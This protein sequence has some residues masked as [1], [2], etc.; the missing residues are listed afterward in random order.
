MRIK[1]LALKAFGPFSDCTLDFSSE[2]PGL[3]VVYGLN[4]AG[5]S[6]SL[7]ALHA[8]FFGFPVRTADNFLHPNDHLLVGGSLQGEDGQELTF[9]R[10]KKS[11]N[12]LFD[13]H[14]NPL[15]PAVLTPFLHGLEQ[16]TFNTLYGIDHDAL[17]RGGQ[18]ILDQQGEVGQALFAAGTGLASL[19]SI[20]DELDGEGDKLFRPRGSSQAI[21]VALTEYR[22]L[23]TQIKQLTLLSREWQGHQRTLD[24]AKKKLENANELRG[25]LNREKRQLER[26]KQALPYLGQRRTLQGK[27]AE[28]GDVVELPFDF[29]D[30]RRKL[31]QQIE[32]ARSRIEAAKSRLHDLKEKRKGISLKQEL[33]DYSDEI[34]ALI[35][36]LG[37]YRKGNIDRPQL[38]G[39]RIG[40]RTEAAKLLKQ[41]RPEISI[42]E[43]E[44]LRPSL[45]KR[46]TIQILGSRHEALLQRVRDTSRLAQTTAKELEK[47]QDDLQK[48]SS[49]VDIEKLSRTITM[50]QK[51]GDLDRDI[52]TKRQNLNNAQEGCLAV[53]SRLGLW[54]GSLELVGQ[55]AVPLPETLHRNEE[56][57]RYLAGEIKQMQTECG[58]LESELAQLNEQLREI[59][60]AADVPNVEELNQNRSRRDQGWKLLRRQWLQGEDVAAESHD[61]DPIHPLPEAYEKLVSISDQTAD[62][63]YREADRVQKHASLRA[64]AEGIEKLLVELN[65]KKRIVEHS[66]AVATRSWEALWAP[67]AINPLPPREMNAWL[68]RFDK[69]RFQVQEADKLA[70]DIKEH[71]VRRRE[72]RTILMAELAAIGEQQ[73]FLGEILS[74]VLQ[75]AEALVR[76][77]QGDQSRREKLTEKIHDLER[78]LESALRDQNEA[79]E[80]LSLWQSRWDE[81]LTP[82]GIERNTLPA[83]AVDFIE[84]LQGCFEKLKEADDFRK[85]IDGID[86]D[87]RGFEEA[88]LNLANQIAPEIA[89]LD[90]I[91][92]VSQL[93]IKLGLA[94][95]DKAL[96]QKYSEDVDDLEKI[97]ID[98]RTELGSFDEQMKAMLH[99]ARCK[100]PEQLI[101]AELRS[102]EYLKL[103]D[104][105][106]EVDVNL[107]RIAEGISLIDLE[108]Q[109]KCI[110]PNALPDRIDGLTKEAEDSIDPEIRQLSEIVG[111]E[112][113]E[114]ARMDGSGKVA[115]LADA[116]QQA[117]VKVQRLTERYIRL[118]L[119]TKLLREEIE[120]YRVENQDPILKIASRYFRQ[121]TLG[122]LTELR[123]DM[124]DQGQPVLIGV[125][126]DGAWL[127]VNGMSSGTRDQL[128]LALRLATLEWRIQS[129]EPIPFII[130]DILI[131][132][133]DQRSKATLKVLCD[134]AEKN[135]VILFTHHSHVIEAAQAL[136]SNDRVFIHKL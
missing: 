88:V 49:V 30:Q 120:R 96:M 71:E 27:L 111:R 61:Y 47:A 1:R 5:K 44:S 43:I 108:E 15:D 29:S 72:I 7:R 94:S 110:D 126:P 54:T 115:E 91:Q 81:T 121:L 53:L 130:D 23:Q 134:L 45:A 57:F 119:A 39:R 103:K 35:Q 107:A 83:E 51:A 125:R 56:E 116:S 11:K 9:F 118:K 133:D 100:T 34:E 8:L 48:H 68:N 127:K 78:V 117:L 131:N 80:A 66:L 74:P 25:I 38:D 98:A 86:R 92:T 132:F 21:S 24:E 40:C 106:E 102:D 6:S 41:I 136:K 90:P 42:N 20:V 129:S 73:S 89:G 112:K 105:L 50:V 77:M 32:E 82:L 26:L 10:R 128:Y 12:S 75:F 4:E 114:L 84:T 67:C 14:D 19:K 46:K 85:R 87:A 93:K 99:I 22:D 31:T 65:E 97:I 101:E 62:R 64:R 59:G 2:S 52:T 28:L 109:A 69:L 135:Q 104:K 55:L 95:Q 60:Y 124:D 113:A 13:K 33:L 17:V 16:D 76:R 18:G 37:Q 70:R 122:S 123:T 36:G 63:L 79:K 3:H 58:Q